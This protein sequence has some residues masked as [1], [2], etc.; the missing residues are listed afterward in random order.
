MG[1]E[2]PVIC[3]QCGHPLGPSEEEIAH[4]EDENPPDDPHFKV[5]IRDDGEERLQCI[6]TGRLAS[7]AGPEDNNIGGDNLSYPELF[8]KHHGE[9]PPG[10][11]EGGGEVGQQSGSGGRQQP[12]PGGIYDVKEEKD[13]MDLL[14]D[15]I[16]NP[17]YGLNDEH[18]QEVQGWAVDM[19]GRLPPNTLEDILKNLKGVQKQTAKLI[20]QRYELKLN[21]WMRDHQSGEE[22]PPIG[23]TTGPMPA[24]SGSSPGNQGATPTPRGK[25]K[26]GNQ[27]QEEQPSDTP[28]RQPRG[29]PSPS[30]N[31]L[32]EYR[33]TRR[34]QRRQETMD[35]AAQRVAE[36]AAD[37]IARELITD[38]GRY[39]SLPAKILEAKIEKDPDWAL[40]KAEQFD[41]D[42]MELMEPSEKRKKEKQQ[43]EKRDAPQVD[44]EVDNALQEV[45]ENGQEQSEQTAETPNTPPH[46]EQDAS[47]MSASPDEQGFSPEPEEPLPEEENEVRQGEE[48]FD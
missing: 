12:T 3:S 32:R 46:E 27:S 5:Q 22:G 37:E 13:Q 25:Q 19:D 15:V 18:I 6:D 11:G 34:T 2:P 1:G 20:R 36:Q 7:P 21:R 26:S 33:R 41:I 39:F 9:L 16:T 24:Q 38:F 4:P 35:I 47:P 17:R 30:P 14:R 44:N 28:D 8:K 45:R 40:E 10:M 43:Q 29:R 48:L 23:V 31:N 42:I